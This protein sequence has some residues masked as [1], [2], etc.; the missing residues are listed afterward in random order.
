MKK[1][2]KKLQFKKEVITKLKMNKVQGG[3]PQY[4]NCCPTQGALNSCPAPGRYCL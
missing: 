4:T 3:N 2:M 1:S